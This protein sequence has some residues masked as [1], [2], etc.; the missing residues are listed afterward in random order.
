MKIIINAEDLTKDKIDWPYI[1]AKL[2][3][4]NS[5]TIECDSWD[6]ALAIQKAAI[7]RKLRTKI[8][9]DCKAVIIAI[10]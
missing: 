3:K 9:K 1:I 4:D 6:E 8:T 5:I 2:N 10:R 7:Y